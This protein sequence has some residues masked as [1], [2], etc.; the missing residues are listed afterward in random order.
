V[1]KSL[2]L[3]KSVQPNG[4]LD[5][6]H[7]HLE[8][9][10]LVT[11]GVVLGMTGSGKT[12]LSMTLLEELTLAGV[13]LILID[14]KGDLPN[15][16]LLFPDFS[17]ASFEAWV[18]P[19]EAQRQGK[20]PA[21][22]AV[23]ASAQ[24]KERLAQWDLDG[25]RIEQLRSKMDLRIYTPGSK[26]GTPVNL[27]GS[28]AC[29]SSDVLEQAESK[30]DL[31]GGTVAGLLSLVGIAADPLRSPEH[32]VLSQILEKAW[33][34]GEDLS[35]ETLISRLVDPPFKKVGVFPLD[36][37][38]P[39]DK[40][41]ELAMRLNSVLASS[42]FALWAQGQPLSPADL[43]TPKDGKVPVSIFYLAHLSD[44][45]RMF[46]VALLLEKLLAHTRTL[47]GTTALRSLLYFDEVAGY[48][49]PTANPASKRPLITLM[50]QSRAVGFGLVLATQN[51]VDIDYKGLSNAGTWIIGRMQM[52]QDRERVADGLTSAEAG[53]DRASLME[54]FE[55]LQARV[56]LVKSP[57][58]AKPT[59]VHTRQAMAYLRG[60]LTRADLERLN[61]PK[62]SSDT[63][64]AAPASSGSSVDG[65]TKRPPICPDGFTQRYLDPRAVFSAQMEGAFESYA[66]PSRSDGKLRMRPALL[67]EMHVRFD[68][69]RGGF[70]HDQHLFRVFFP[71]DDGIKAAFNV[72]LQSGDILEVAPSEGLFE[73]L[74]TSLDE[75]QELKAA[76]KAVVDET[77][78]NVTSSQFIHAGL[79]LYGAGGQT[80]EEF[81]SVVEAAIQERIDAQVA[82]LNEKVQKEVT[83]LQE[84]IT[85]HQAKVSQLESQ[86]QGRQIEQIWNAGAALLGFFT[87]SKKSVASAVGTVM[88]KNRLRSQSAQRSESAGSELE[89]LQTKLDEIQEKLESDV[90]AIEEKE[91]A[92]LTNIEEKSVRLETSDIRL[93]Y[94]GI[95]WIPVSRRV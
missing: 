15:L 80:R 63:V 51:P 32:I 41:M 14:P 54:H 22:L 88:T 42:S 12:G 49:P 64:V 59:L 47:S 95:L 2:F 40:R 46:F 86:T 8:G 58:Q 3:G 90:A 11:H 50:K 31:I 5:S 52:S 43:C 85:K 71:I 78:R 28:F 24:Q 82:K 9:D 18:D 33:S 17:P 53:F 48:V 21:E 94:F 45:E 70:V 1:A 68:E 66:E 25:S 35:L 60:P 37:F 91:K 20:S 34:E 75:P 79:K 38:Y 13:P 76:Q 36:T 57:G 16:G 69:D 27:L 6:T 87:G 61:I 26:A 72:D 65:L 55:R 23:L 92:A 77:F 39:S 83:T 81:E 29:P 67:A 4:E 56:F 30:S 19:Q 89:R 7:F 74:P 93:A 62:S 10:A 44:S 73:S 84:K